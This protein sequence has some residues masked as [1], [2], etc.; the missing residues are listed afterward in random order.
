MPPKKKKRKQDQKTRAE[1]HYKH[2]LAA[3]T[4]DLKLTGVAQSVLE[5][6]ARKHFDQRFLGVFPRDM[7]PD[8]H[9]CKTGCCFIVNN[10]PSTM[11]GEHWL[12]L[13]KTE[14]G[15]WQCY[16]SFGRRDFLRLGKG[17]SR[18]TE[19]DAE[20]KDEEINC[21]NRS[22]AWCAVFLWH[23]PEMSKWI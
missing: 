6:Y 1:E 11:Q 13:G 23:G 21:G 7:M 10:E 5:N 4:K 3:I 9:E 19:H 20:Q 18:D 14:D 16:D 8:L 12:G 22:L 15:K 2:I 17:R